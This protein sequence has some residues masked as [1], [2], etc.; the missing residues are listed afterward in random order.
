MPLL[1]KTPE[2][3]NQIKMVTLESQ[4]PQGSEVRLLDE[5]VDSFFEHQDMD[6]IACIQNE[7]T[8]ASAFSPKE[9]L[10]LLAYGYRN[11]IN[12]SRRLEAA[13]YNNIE[14]MFLLGNLHPSYHTIA[15]FRAANKVLFESF[16]SFVRD[17]VLAL[18]KKGEPTTV[19]IDGT[20]FK[21]YASKT[22]LQKC[23]D[24]LR[25]A[26]RE[27]ETYL[28]E[29]EKMDR[30]EDVEEENSSLR[31]ELE[32]TKEKL[33]E[34]ESKVKN[35]EAKVKEEETKPQRFVNDSD[36]RC[37]KHKGG[38]FD[39]SYNTEVVTEKELH[40]VMTYAV[41]DDANDVQQLAPVSI[42]ALSV[43]KEN[44]IDVNKLVGD[45]GFCNV[46]H[47]QELEKL[48]VDCIVGV[49]NVS[50]REKDKA[51]GISFNYDR[52]NKLVT[53]C[54]GK[55]LE[56][57]S[58]KEHRGINYDVFRASEKDCANCPLRNKCTSSKH[59]RSVW[60]SAEHEWKEE[61]RKKI[62]HPENKELLRDRFGMIEN[63]FG[64]IKYWAGKCPLL[65][66][67][68]KK[69]CSEVALYMSSYNIVRLV[70]LC[71]FGRKLVLGTQ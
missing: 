67:T 58:T 24:D 61:F 71:G 31:E 44:G 46:K 3:R 50:Q 36:A 13:T 21:A 11:R 69:V 27:L 22:T 65:L 43:A 4:I 68:M 53:C 48:G 39:A 66:T 47:I 9:L 6:K 55:R 34:L 33:L 40:I 23:K 38:Q 28:N 32:R 29:V 2:P 26:Q 51:N 62:E 5:L 12:S 25:K 8:G 63:V 52:D 14:V 16:F 20:K 42:D 70:N 7:K 37:M 17:T 1:F 35:A 45:S 64:T 49:P 18:C 15:S 56:F 10:K 59:G 60:V 30:I 19:A 54:R 57:V 41:T